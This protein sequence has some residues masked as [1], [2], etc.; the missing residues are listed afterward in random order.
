MLRRDAGER[1][2]G[3]RDDDDLVYGWEDWDLW[4]RL[5]EL[6]R[7]RRAGAADPRPVPGAGGLDDR[8][9]PT[10]PPM[11]PSTTSAQRYPSLPWPS[12]AVGVSTVGA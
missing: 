7:P 3:Y 9:R 10:W 1:L 2:G 12:A 11:K 5:A 6:G 8:A 4:L